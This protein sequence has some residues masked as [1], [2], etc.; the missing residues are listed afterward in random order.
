[1][2]SAAIPMAIPISMGAEQTRSP[3]A[4]SDKVAGEVDATVPSFAQRLS[5]SVGESEIV[6]GSSPEGKL[7]N[8]LP[9]LKDAS[10]A[11]RVDGRTGRPS[12]MKGA[13]VGQKLIAP[14]QSESKD[15]ARI[16]SRSAAPLAAQGEISDVPSA[17]DLKDSQQIEGSF[18]ELSGDPIVSQGSTGR[19]LITTDPKQSGVIGDRPA[20]PI[21]A[22]ALVLNGAADE[23]KAR[24]SNSAKEVSRP[25]GGVSGPKAGQRPTG[26]SL[27]GSSMTAAPV[28]SLVASAIPVVQQ[29]DQTSVAIQR[30][31]VQTAMGLT[32]TVSRGE[33]AR[34]RSA[35]GNAPGGKEALNGTKAAVLN[36]EE[37]GVPADAAGGVQKPDAEGSNES[38]LQPVRDVASTPEPA[39]SKVHSLVEGLGVSPAI[40]IETGAIGYQG[41]VGHPATLS[42]LTAG[43][44][45]TD[46]VSASREQDG[47]TAGPVPLEDAPRM[48]AA[49]PTTLEVGIQ[50]GTHGWLKVRAEIGDGGGIN[51]SVLAPSFSAKEMLNREVPSLSTYL[52]QEKIAVNSV[53]IHSP[54]ATTV[55]SNAQS[56]S[57]ESGAGGQTS[58]RG[59]QEGKHLETSG[60]VRADGR[61]DGI[62]NPEVSEDGLLLPAIYAGGGSWLS[63]RA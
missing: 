50:N 23:T 63:V 9:G 58:Q 20:A 47:R 60:N 42:S 28:G 22:G 26:A 24:G 17:K 13:I 39:A 37:V 29:V 56:L 31:F 57:F 40:G 3:A 18:E 53:V 61:K 43:A 4:S 15:A 33:R 27:D 16:S 59:G 35:A 10:I 21:V 30:E 51:A 46:V 34:V 45:T 5:E 55:E 14:G 32:G 6:K 48:L 12:S 62:G 7:E 49:T 38:A 36:P 1:M 44:H 11:E 19:A 25:H 52:E 2:T 41:A 54:I 8:L